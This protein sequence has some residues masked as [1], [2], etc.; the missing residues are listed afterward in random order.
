MYRSASSVSYHKSPSNGFEGA[1]LPTDVADVIREMSST[2]ASALVK[3]SVLLAA[4]YAPEATDVFAVADVFATPERKV[5]GQ[6]SYVTPST[7]CT[8]PVTGC[9]GS[10]RPMWFTIPPSG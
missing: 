6:Q 10:G 5:G 3:L 9:A 4:E 2:L 8:G 1:V 7:G